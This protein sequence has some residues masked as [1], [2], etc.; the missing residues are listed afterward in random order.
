MPN[1]KAL[2]PDERIINRISFGIMICDF[3]AGL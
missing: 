1:K 3:K 2:I